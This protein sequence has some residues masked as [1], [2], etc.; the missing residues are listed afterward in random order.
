MDG[1]QDTRSD[2]VSSSSSIAVHSETPLASADQALPV[3]PLDGAEHSYLSHQVPPRTQSIPNSNHLSPSSDTQFAAADKNVPLQQAANAI[4][5]AHADGSW[6][7]AGQQAQQVAPGSH[8]SGSSQHKPRTTKG[9]KATS[10][11]WWWEILATILS[12][13]CMGALTVILAKIDNIPLPHWWLPIQPNSLIAV[14]T[15]VAKSSMM[16]S[17][18]SCISQLKWGHFF[19]Q[20]RKL[21][22]LET[23]DEASRGPWGS[24]T[25]LPL[26]AF[27]GPILFTSGLALVTIVSLGIDPC[28]QQVLEFPTQ[29]TPLDNMTVEMGVANQYFSKGMR[30]DPHRSKMPSFR[31]TIAHT[32]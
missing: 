26:L 11:W 30:E 10:W 28:A 21:V 12:I 14:L 9:R 31:P 16:L 17:V 32:I 24:A 7:P 23:F 20:P 6:Q 22:D 5:V 19:Q 2:P 18:A 3:S 13:A 29:L 25:L 15:T 27:R 4:S 1:G 8:G